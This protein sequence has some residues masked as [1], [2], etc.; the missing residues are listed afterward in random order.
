MKRHPDLLFF[1]LLLAVSLFYGYH[2]ILFARP[3]FHH[4]W[5]QTDC[6]SITMN[7]FCDNRDFFRPAINWVGDKGGRTI[8]EFPII[9]FTVAQLWKVFGFHEFIY[10]LIDVLLVFTGLFSLYRFSR[11][12]LADTFWAL[13]IPFFLFSSPILAYFTNNF[14]AD[15]PALGIVITACYLYWRGFREQSNKWYYLSFLLFLLAG[16]L[17]ISSLIVFIALFILQLYYVVFRRGEKNWFSRLFR[18]WPYMVVSVLI[19]AWY[20]YAGNYNS[21]N[22]NGFFLHG[23]LPIWGIDAAAR[24]EVWKSF[25]KTLIPNFFTV[26][27]LVFVMAL[28]VSMFIFIKKINRYFL[29][30]SLLIFIGS[31]GFIILFYQVFNVHDYYLTNL[32]IFIPLPVIAILDLLRRQYPAVFHSLVLKTVA[33]AAV[34]VL[35]YIGAVNTRMRYFPRQAFV[36]KNLVVNK[37]EISDW[38]MWSDYCGTYFNA[39]KTI[40]PYLRSIGIKR[41]DLVYSTPDGTINV[42]LYLMDQKGFSDFYIG[43][44]SEDQRMEKV[45]ELGVRYLIIN[46]TSICRKP[47]LAP[48]L[49]H[50]VGAYKNVVIYDLNL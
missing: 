17:K 42:T 37:K 1:A 47:F 40:T 48:Y 7:Y 13:L 16:L 49:H 22:L 41:D 20:D 27:A 46:D 19:F 2:D 43:G 29:F 36:Q 33:V 4:I 14:L 10:R 9:Y 24:Q 12:F 39:F 25:M 30:L 3:G 18:L 11:E 31:I 44:I 28:F 5:R 45:K 34:L 6:L 26:P 15:A 50:K 8:S 21:H 38:I 23:I 35:L 32:L